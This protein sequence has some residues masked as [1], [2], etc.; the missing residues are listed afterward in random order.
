M[1]AIVCI[2]D[3]G[4]I[5]FNNRRV[6]RDKVLTSWITEYTAGRT[7]WM[8]PYSKELF[9]SANADEIVNQ[10]V[11]ISEDYLSE[12]KNGDF[13]FVEDDGLSLFEQYGNSLEALL[14]CRWNRSYPSDVRLPD[15]LEALLPEKV[16]IDEFEG[17]SHD[18]IT[19]EK[20][21][22]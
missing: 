6:S 16:V 4:G 14:I 18:K 21:C 9:S 3:N 10:T 7:L 2:D 12:A 20:W 15:G 17:N 5:L 8:R 11:K 13:C 22:R 19:I 1:I